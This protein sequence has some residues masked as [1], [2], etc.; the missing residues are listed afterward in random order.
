MDVT[1]INN[2]IKTRNICLKATWTHYYPF[3]YYDDLF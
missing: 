3:T 1:D 2:I